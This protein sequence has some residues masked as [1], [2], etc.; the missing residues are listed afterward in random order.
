LHPYFGNR[1]LGVL[2]IWIGFGLLKLRSGWR[3]C[4][5]VF[6]WIA[7]I[8]IPLVCLIFLTAHRPLDVAVL[9]QSAGHTSP[10]VGA[11]IGILLFALSLWEYGV[12]TR[13]DVRRLFGLPEA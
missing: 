13:P 7:L 12:L 11:V 5:L 10:A 8:G 1:T 9:G 3:A 4:G 2:G 6:I